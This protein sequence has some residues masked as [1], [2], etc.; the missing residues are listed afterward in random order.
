MPRMVSPKPCQSVTGAGRPMKTGIARMKPARDSR[1]RSISK[2]TLLRHILLLLGLVAV[3]GLDLEGAISLTGSTV[4]RSTPGPG[5]TFEGVIKIQNTD[6]NDTSVRM[7]VSDY[8][9]GTNGASLFAEPGTFPR[10]NGKW[11]TVDTRQVDI[12][13]KELREVRYRGTVPLDPN[14]DGSYW[15]LVFAEEQAPVPAL[16]TNLL[17]RTPQA[18]IRTVVRFATIILND[19]GDRVDPSLKVMERRV[20]QT[21][22]LKAL[23]LLIENRGNRMIVPVPSLEVLD[24]EGASVGKID[25]NPA[26]IFPGSAVRLNFDLTGVAK[27]KYSG[28]VVLDTG[29][30]AN[31]MAAKCPIELVH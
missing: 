4:H 30:P 22:D 9:T 14:L 31:L 20:V 23:S 26:R 5:G 19:I 24:G 27:G 1:P 18:A 8:R 25:L 12:P 15:S 21:N 17:S 6:T 3:Q 2:T 29:D 11:I 28:I 16:V 13:A 7:Y 10:S